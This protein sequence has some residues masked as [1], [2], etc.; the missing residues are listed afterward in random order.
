MITDND[1]AMPC[2]DCGAP[3]SSRDEPGEYYMVT[4][5][6]WTA[7]GMHPEHITRVHRDGSWT[8]VT[9]NGRGHVTGGPFPSE[10]LC[11]G[12]LEKRLGR[13]LSG[14][15]FIDCPLNAM[16]ERQTARLRSRI[17]RT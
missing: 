16:S 2:N 11:V 5:E 9:T 3:T 6:I 7:A 10:Y 4:S 1:P 17:R 15:D 14:A 8:R 12:C 13:T